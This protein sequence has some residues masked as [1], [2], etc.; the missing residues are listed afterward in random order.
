MG[1]S[2]VRD[3]P[4]NIVTICSW[5]NNA[6]ESDPK[7]AELARELGWKLRAGADPKTESVYHF[8]H[9]WITLDDSFGFQNELAVH[10]S[11]QKDSRG[12]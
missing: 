11:R 3:V 8:R 1:G 2:K 12:I 5:L 7:T 6:M 9:G 4:S 10:I